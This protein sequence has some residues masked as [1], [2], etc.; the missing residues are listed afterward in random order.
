MSHPYKSDPMEHQV[1]GLRRAWRKRSFALFWEM[2][3]GKTFTTV[4]LAAAR[5]NKDQ[6]DSLLIICPTPIKLVWESEFEKWCP[7][8]Y[9]MHVL[10]SGKKN[11]EDMVYFTAKE[12][13][14]LKV[15]V[16]GVEA[17]SQ[18]KAANLCHVFCKMHTPMAV[19][20]ESSRLKNAQ[21]GR[22]KRAIEIGAECEFRMI[23]TGTPVTQGIHDLYGQFAFLNPAIIGCKSFFQFRNRYCVMG[24]F[25]QRSIV[26]YQHTEELMGRVSPYV[27]IVK[28]ED[29]LDLPPKTYEKITVEPSPAQ[30][31]LIKQL[32]DV[33][34]AEHGGETLIAETILE[35]LT[36][37]QQIIGG[38][39]P[40]QV[41]DGKYDT[42]PIEGKNP[43]LNALYEVL[44]DLPI[45]TKVI[46]WARFV[47]EIETIRNLILETFGKPSVVTFYGKD[48][49]DQRKE[50]VVE[51]MEGRARFM[52]SNP[53]LGGMG[54]T[55][56]AATVVIY[57][58]NSF[59]YE[60][61]RQSED[62]A[63]R[64]GQEHAVTY[65]DIEANHAYD[66]MI[67]SAIKQK[68]G[69]ARY[70]DEKIYANQE[71]TEG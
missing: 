7:V 3:T 53:Q 69:M 62:R 63:H 34:E 13:D 22:T 23:L 8:E 68:G 20:D 40:F 46:I 32:K 24:G 50:N 57:F 61:R 9:E 60:D 37:F 67:L 36:R 31:D 11:H 64:K 38:N 15:V 6:I 71:A 2:G 45:E 30:L 43:K 51:F 41:E 49:D 48:T 47:P 59:S 21:A 5:Y 39:F 58:S 18:G 29:V 55:W 54:Q 1:V 42:K 19:C 14:A 66:K 65:L 70:V 52:I 12:T 28:K 16:V 17:L 33:F 44:E 4:N 25:E 26:G 56:T 27:D 35:R 10:Q